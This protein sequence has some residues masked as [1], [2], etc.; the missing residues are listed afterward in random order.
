L[1]RQNEKRREGGAAVEHR[2]GGQGPL[3]RAM[4]GGDGD[5][6]K[7][8]K[9]GGEE[10]EKEK[11]CPQFQTEGGGTTQSKNQKGL[12]Q[13]AEKKEERFSCTAI[14]REKGGRRNQRK[15]KTRNGK[16]G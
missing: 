14:G 1:G 2:G 5:R 7:G 9:G 11:R 13:R 6:R 3:N 16:R 12:R 4:K 8:V 10:R 15:V